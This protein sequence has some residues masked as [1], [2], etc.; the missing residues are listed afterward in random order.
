MY[1]IPHNDKKQYFFISFTVN[2]EEATVIR[3][4]VGKINKKW[5]YYII[6]IGDK[7]WYNNTLAKSRY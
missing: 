5:K 1:I 4:I 2:Y 7:N 3:A 6:Y